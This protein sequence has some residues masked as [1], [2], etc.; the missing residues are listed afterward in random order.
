[1]NTTDKFLVFIIF[2]TDILIILNH[3]LQMILIDLLK[4]GIYLCDIRLQIDD[5]GIE[6]MGDL[7]KCWNQ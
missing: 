6:I 1:M 3:A 2:L 4:I 5:I 7:I